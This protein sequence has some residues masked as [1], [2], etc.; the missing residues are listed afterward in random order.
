M[1]N[2]AQVMWAALV[3]G[4]LGALASGL[5]AG[6]T[7][8]STGQSDRAA[9]IVAVMAFAGVIVT[10]VAVEGTVDAKRAK[11]GTVWPSDVGRDVTTT[12]VNAPVPPAPGNAL[13]KS[14]S[15]DDL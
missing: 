5:I 13:G 8:L 3:R 2:S 4:I 10:R 14:V 15:S 9:L 12:V 11:T 1:D 7:A 6:G